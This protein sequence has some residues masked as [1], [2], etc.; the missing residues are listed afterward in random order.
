LGLNVALVAAVADDRFGREIIDHLQDE[1]VD[2]SLLKVVGEARTPFTGIVEFELGDS[3]ALT[4]PNRRNVRLEIDDVDRLRQHF[5]AAD[6]VLL[7]FE[8]PRETLPVH[9]GR[10]EKAG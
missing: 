4:W 6:A 9:I 10:S 1:Q 8:I 3:L 2:T 5:A 7:T